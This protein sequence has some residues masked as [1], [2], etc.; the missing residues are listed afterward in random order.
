MQYIEATNYSQSDAQED[1]LWLVSL[2]E[3]P[4]WKEIG[5]VVHP[6]TLLPDGSATRISSQW[7]A[8]KEDQNGDAEYFG[9][10]LDQAIRSLVYDDDPG[11]ALDGPIIYRTP[12]DWAPAECWP[13][14]KPT[15]DTTDF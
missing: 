7:I 15:V 11:T 10:D 13:I 14:Y 3:G 8:R 9:P 4:V 12:A 2:H 1:R 5:A 6:Y